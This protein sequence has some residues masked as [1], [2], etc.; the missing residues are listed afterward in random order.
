MT[1]LERRDFL[2]RFGALSV[3]GLFVPETAGLFTGDLRSPLQRREDR[4]EY[5]AVF[6]CY[7]KMVFAGPAL[8]EARKSDEKFNQIVE[9]EISGFRRDMKSW[10]KRP[11]REVWPEGY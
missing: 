1:S 2:K 8:Y 9:Q 6:H 10:L 7:G 4:N 5:E 3:G 11:L